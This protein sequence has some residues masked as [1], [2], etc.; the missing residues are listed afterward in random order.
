MRK[1][2]LL[3]PLLC[4]ACTERD[5]ASGGKYTIETSIYDK[6]AA[7]RDS[8]GNGIRDDIDLLLQERREFNVTPAARKYSENLARAFQVTAASAPKDEQEAIE[9]LDMVGLQIGCFVNR[10]PEDV[11]FETWDLIRVNTYNTLDRLRNK[12]EHDILASGTAFNTTGET[13]CS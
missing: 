9:R 4:A 1:I 8:D 6:D 12:E 11:Y 10:M 13:G 7:G 5:P 3:L 2:L